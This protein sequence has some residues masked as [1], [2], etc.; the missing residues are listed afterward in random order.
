MKVIFDCNIWVSF[1]IGHYLTEVREMLTSPT[2]EVYSCPQLMAEV[3]D[4]TGRDKIRRHVTHTDVEDLLRIIRA[5]CRNVELVHKATSAVRDPKDLYLL[6][7]AETV[8]ADYLV[9]G[10]S[11]LLVLGQHKNTQLIK[12]SD[13]RRLT[14]KKKKTDESL[15]Q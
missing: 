4:V 13:F 14:N 6:S 10:D 9:S 8:G 12:L 1:L 7:L 2:V 3:V 5:Y 15:Y 11:D